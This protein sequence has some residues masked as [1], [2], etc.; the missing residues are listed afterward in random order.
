MIF[1]GNK[2]EKLRFSRIRPRINARICSVR[3][4]ELQKIC[5]FRLFSSPSPKSEYGTTFKNAPFNFTSFKTILV[6]ST[7]VWVATKVCAYGNYKLFLRNT[8]DL[9]PWIQFSMQKATVTSPYLDLRF[10]KISR[11]NIILTEVH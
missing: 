3:D 9:L 2:K 1:Q 7:Y 4:R 11:I 8:I 6:L 10:I 5:S